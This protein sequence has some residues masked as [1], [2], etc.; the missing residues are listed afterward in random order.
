M[1]TLPN[2]PAAVSHEIFATLC[3]ALPAPASDTPENR[4][5]R[6]EAGMAAVAA[7]HPTDAFEAKLAAEIVVADAYVMDSLRLAGQYRDDLAATLRCRAQAT[8][9]MRQMRGGLRELQRI[10]A[11]REKAE[12]AIHPAAMQSAGDWFC[13]ASVPL[14]DQTEALDQTEA[15]DWPGLTEAEQYAALYPDRAALIRAAGGLPARLNFGPPEPDI[16]AAIVRGRSP[17]LRALDRP[18]EVATA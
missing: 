6:D 12:A 2:L 13:D 1:H 4:A 3:A 15:P 17:A 18:P 10:Q 7:L 8:S 9:M 11:E 5:A 14:P 16:V